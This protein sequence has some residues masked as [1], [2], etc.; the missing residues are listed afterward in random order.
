MT[1]TRG[2]LVEVVAVSM[3]RSLKG[4]IAVRNYPIVVY[5]RQTIMGFTWPPHQGD[6][7]CDRHDQ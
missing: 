4:T 2:R 6:I 1:T 7:M 3:Q 5:A